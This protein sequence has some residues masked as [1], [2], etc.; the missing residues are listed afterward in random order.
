LKGRVVVTRSHLSLRPPRGGRMC[1]TRLGVMIA[2]GWEQRLSRFHGDESSLG[3]GVA[4]MR[5][6]AF[7][8]S[9]MLCGPWRGSRALA[10]LF[11]VLARDPHEPR[12]RARAPLELCCDTTQLAGPAVLFA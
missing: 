12:P 10:Q 6:V 9:S 3:L 4:A 8:L 7:E 2:W 11:E 1:G 5:P